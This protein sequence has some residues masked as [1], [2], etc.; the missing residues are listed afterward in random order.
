MFFKHVEA[1]S[2]SAGIR[3]DKNIRRIINHPDKVAE[4]MLKGFVF[5]PLSLVAATALVSQRFG[6]LSKLDSRR[7]NDMTLHL[8]VYSSC[9][10]LIGRWYCQ[11]TAE[12]VRR[13]SWGNIRELKAAIMEYV[14]LEQQGPSLCLDQERQ[15]R[16]LRKGTCRLALASFRVSL[17]Y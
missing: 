10:S 1:Q 12:R 6:F 11:I 3:G 5:A 16:S 13:G 2:L 15:P 9:L 17:M 7:D 4:D 8:I 14:H